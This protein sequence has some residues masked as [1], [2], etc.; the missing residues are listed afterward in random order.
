MLRALAMVMGA[1]ASKNGSK[2]NS[3]DY[4]TTTAENR[5]C[6]QLNMWQHATI[7]KK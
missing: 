4:T 1:L 7:N 2:N 3:N 5:R 6:K